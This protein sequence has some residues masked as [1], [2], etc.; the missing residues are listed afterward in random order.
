MAQCWTKSVVGMVFAAALAVPS[1]AAP[2]TLSQSIT[3]VN[4]V[5]AGIAGVGG[6]SGTITVAGV[7]GTVTAAFLYWHGI[8][9]TAFGGNGI[10]DNASITLNAAPV[11]GT[12]IGDSTTNCFGPGSS[13]SYRANVTALVTGNGAYAVAGLSAGAGHNANGASLVVLFDDGNAANNRTLAFFEGNDSDNNTDIPFPGEATGWQASLPVNYAGGTVNAQFHVGDGQTF[14][15]DFIQLNADTPGVISDSPLFWDGLSVPTAGTSRTTSGQLWD[16]HTFNI[17][18]LFTSSGPK[19]L[20]VN[21]MNN[22]EDCHS[23][24]LL[25]LDFPA[26]AVINPAAEPIPTASEYGLAALA[27]LLS[28]AGLWAVR[29]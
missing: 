10:Y 3:G 26:S 29:R 13:R 7:T 8:D 5:S 2:V 28:L 6:G 11:V 4:Y 18:G 27:V 20:S 25:L 16:I 12:A 17:T 9:R 23:L 1:A 15:D 24:V 14:P 22:S 21:G 19:T